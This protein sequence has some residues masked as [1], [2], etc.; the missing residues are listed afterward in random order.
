MDRFWQ[1]EPQ[2]FVLWVAGLAVLLAIAYYVLGVIRP[3]PSQKEPQAS[4]WLSKFREL[5]DEGGL[6]DEEFREI[7][8]TLGA[9][10]RDELSDNDE[11]G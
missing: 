10:L 5:H 9:Q 3:K 6:S 4:R 2:W 8:T 1:S 11:K 7:R